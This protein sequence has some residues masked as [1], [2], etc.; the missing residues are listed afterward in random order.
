[1]DDLPV[2]PTIRS[3]WFVSEQDELGGADTGAGSGT[4]HPRGLLRSNPPV[5]PSTWVEPP[6]GSPAPPLLPSVR[7]DDEPPTAQPGW[8]QPADRWA[9]PLDPP[10]QRGLPA[11]RRTGPTTDPFPADSPPLPRAS[12][13]P[14]ARGG[15][16][17]ETG[18]P[19]RQRRASLAPELRGTPLTEPATPPLLAGTRSPDEIRSMMSSFQ[20][21]FGRGLQER[22]NPNGGD[23]AKKVM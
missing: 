15:K 20:S 17:D 3:S 16:P 18:L 21:N 9:D 23:D 1:M 4:E 8:P 11:R 14:A 12:A 22:P 6:S 5:E 19:K 7:W 13:A 2:F 10:Q